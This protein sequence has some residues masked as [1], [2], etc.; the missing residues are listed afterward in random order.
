MH[1]VPLRHRLTADRSDGRYVVVAVLA[2]ADE[3][4]PVRWSA[5]AKPPEPL[6][7]KRRPMAYVIMSDCADVLDRTCVTVCPVDCIYEGER[8]SYIQPNECIDCGACEPVCPVEA[9]AYE[10]EVPAGE[11]QHIGDNRA[12]FTTILP[13]RTEPV[14]SPRGAKKVGRIGVDTPLVA[15]LA[16]EPATE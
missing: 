9:I 16:S 15:Q 7:R 1:A 11:E 10:E 14:G 2:Y 4:E 8:A 5:S 6:E 13:G 12:F 3:P